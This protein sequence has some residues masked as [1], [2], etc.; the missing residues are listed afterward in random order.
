MNAIAYQKTPAE[1]KREAVL[2]CT[3]LLA[4]GWVNIYLYQPTGKL[5]RGWGTWP[6][7][8]KAVQALREIG[9]AP[10]D[11]YQG[12]MPACEWCESANAPSSA[13]AGR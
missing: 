11:V 12:T 8:E 10:G 3:D 13:T 1:A 9:A 6:T 7:A 2:C 5:H 4:D